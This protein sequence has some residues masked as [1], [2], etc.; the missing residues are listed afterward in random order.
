[1]FRK[2][3]VVMPVTS[4]SSLIWILPLLILSGGL[5]FWLYTNST[6][7]SGLETKWKWSLRLLRTSS[8]FLISLLLLGIIFESTNY[9]SE[10][11]VLITLVDDSKSML[12]YADS[13]KVRNN[14]RALIDQI[15]TSLSDKYE[16]VFMTSGNRTDYGKPSTFNSE[17]SNHSLAFEKIHTDFYSRNVGAILFVSDGNFN[18]GAHPIYSAKKINFTPVYTLGVGDTIPKRDQLIKHVTSNDIVFYKNKFPIEVDLEAIKMGKTPATISVYSNGQKVA[19]QTVSYSGGKAD[20]KQVTFEIEAKKIGVQSYTIQVNK[21]ANEF[22][23]ENNSKTVYIEVVDSRNTVLCLSGAPHPDIAAI[24]DVLG[25]DENLQIK[26]A[27]ARTWDRKIDGI[28]LVIWHEP[29]IAYDQTIADQLK[30]KKIPVWFILGPYTNAA[31]TS[32]LEIGISTT[33]NNQADE[34]QG[35]WVDGFSLFEISQ[36]TKEAIPFF[37]PLRSKFG[38]LKVNSSA[39]IA[40]IQKVGPVRKKDPLLFFG[41]RNTTR[42]GVLYGEGIWRW[43]MNDFLRTGNTES[44]GELVAKT[45]QYLLIRQPNSP[46]RVQCEKRYS[47]EEEV[48]FNATFYNAAMEPITIP[49]VQLEVRNEKGQKIKNVFAKFETY[50]KL[51]LGKMQ[52][53][54]YTWKAYTT[55][56]GKSYVKNGFFIVEDIQLEQIDNYA[57]HHQLRQLSIG[58]GGKYNELKSYKKAIDELKNRKDITSVSYKDSSYS[59]LIDWKLLFLLIGILLTV[60]WFLRRWLGSY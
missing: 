17:V 42:F 19:S 25:R 41:T 60:E 14:T 38:E 32:K 39:E 53:G 22:N 59:D 35:D 20:F 51:S 28:D 44:F 55:F 37:P 13:N 24:K 27:S 29:G 40:L 3:E 31:V 5:A 33:S 21:A 23:Y 56:K 47:K 34:V 50:Y 18:K 16:L 26:S 45:T 9:R 7:F 6:W 48:L 36:K 8:L 46:L 57:F 54:K 2:F 58:T 43:K 11:P 30:A 15:E 49:A 10:K 52:P 4:D 1:M 12:N